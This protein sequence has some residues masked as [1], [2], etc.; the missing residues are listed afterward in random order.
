MS[1]LYDLIRT[2]HI[3]GGMAGLALAIVP[4]IT[5]KGARL[6]RQTG[7]WFTRAMAV[8]GITGLILSASWL[9]APAHFHPARVTDPVLARISG[10]FLGTIALVTLAALQQM[11]GSL[12]RKRRPAPAPSA[13]DLALPITMAAAGLASIAT[14]VLTQRGLLVVFGALAVANCISDL[15][16]VLRPLPTRMAWWYQHMRAA[17]GAII[18][19]VTALLVFGANRVIEGVLPPALAWVPWVAPAAIAVPLFSL[20]IARFRRRFGEVA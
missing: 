8:A 3:L 11:L 16:F 15:R 19:A 18:T 4:L 20:W 2:L 7:R 12:A 1:L 9:I 13:L 14:G 5:R 17:M 6:H 10:L